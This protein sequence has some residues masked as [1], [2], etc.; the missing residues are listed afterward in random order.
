MRAALKVM[1]PIHITVDVNTVR[2]EWCISAVAAATLGHR[3]W[4]T[5]W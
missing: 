3:C 4:C 5:F 1:P 2:V